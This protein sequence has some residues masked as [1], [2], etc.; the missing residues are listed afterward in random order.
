M[1]QGA[2]VK[3]P[4]MRQ[5]PQVSLPPQTTRASGES[6]CEVH[7]E[8]MEGITLGDYHMSSVWITDYRPICHLQAEAD[9]PS[10]R[11]LGQS[12]V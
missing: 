8:L 5:N 11:G 12:H 7:M 1:I 9:T 6:L 3:A 2:G 4:L 10:P